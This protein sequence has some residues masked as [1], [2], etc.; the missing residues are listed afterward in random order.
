[1]M[2]GWLAKT[3]L[4]GFLTSW[5]DTLRDRCWPLNASLKRGERWIS[6]VGVVIVRKVE[7]SYLINP[8]HVLYAQIPSNRTC[9]LNQC[10][11]CLQARFWGIFHSAKPRRNILSSANQCVCRNLSVGKET[12]SVQS[13]SCSTI[14]ACKYF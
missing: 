2:F 11:A 13:I 1:M 5:R 9:E 10:T 7:W 3:S 12:L 4:F 6:I 8:G 14:I